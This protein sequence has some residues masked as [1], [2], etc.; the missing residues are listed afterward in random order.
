MIPI[1]QKMVGEE[2]QEL[3]RN[4]IR[5]ALRPVR[6]SDLLCAILLNSD[7]AVSSETWGVIVEDEVISFLQKQSLLGTA[8]AFL[9]EYLALKK[10]QRGD[11]LEK[12][13]DRLLKKMSNRLAEDGT[14]EAEVLL[15][16]IFRQGLITIED[17]T[18]KLRDKILLERLTDKFLTYTQQFFDQLDQA[19]EKEVFLNAAHNFIKM[20]PEL[21]HRE[22]YPEI[23]RIVETLSKHFHEKRM[24]ALLA[25]QILEE[26]AKGSIPQLLK[27]KFLTGKKEVRVAIVPIL[28]ALDIGAI[29]ILLEILKTSEDQWVRKNACEVLIQ[30][31][32]VAAAHLL[33]ELEEQQISIET[34]CNILRVLG[35]IKPQQWK[36]PLMRLLRNYVSHENPKLREQAIY[37]LCQ[38]GGPEGETVFLSSLNDP[39]LE[40]QK[41]AVWCLGMIKSAKGVEKMIGI[42]KQISATP[43]PPLEQLETKIYHSFGL[44]GNLT[45]EEKTLEKILL[46]VV[47]KRGMVGLLGFFQK[48]PLSDSS[49]GAIC[50]ALGKIGTKGSVKVLARLEKSHKGPLALKVGEALKKIEERIQR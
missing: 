6:Q 34:I 45:I 36:T 33:T 19:K 43:S 24:W 27:E 23:L 13:S 7:L 38:I 1:I 25:G 47:E 42:L 41:R 15:E 26:V 30:I 14:G 16:Q 9:Q 39:D 31:G 11:A 44:S 17:L 37:A 8:K 2:L 29:P 40:V 28:T 48:N 46:E 20:I 35:E 12:K 32:P 18:P 3:R 21:I 10:L 49:L 22:R 5:D 50:D 4:L